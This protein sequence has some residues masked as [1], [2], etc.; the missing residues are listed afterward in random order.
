MNQDSLEMALLFV[1]LTMSFWT[2]SAAPL[3]TRDLLVRISYKF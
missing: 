1:A 2:I 3:Y